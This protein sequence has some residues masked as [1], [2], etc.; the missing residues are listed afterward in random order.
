M[1]QH[2]G[3]RAEERSP[4][5]APKLALFGCFYKLGTKPGEAR[6]LAPKGRFFEKVGLWRSGGG[7]SHVRVGWLCP[8]GCL[9][10]IYCLCCGDKMVI[11]L[12]T[13]ALHCTCRKVVSTSSGHLVLTWL[14]GHLVFFCPGLKSLYCL[15]SF[16]KRA[17]RAQR[18]G[19][20][21]LRH[22]GWVSMK[23]QKFA[24]HPPVK[25]PILFLITLVIRKF[26]VIVLA[27]IIECLPQ[28]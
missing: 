6:V 20:F 23:S 7:I 25:C 24:T 17:A 9:A 15:R 11:L 5:L 21:F 13:A 27:N 3:G 14:P 22:L 26:I 10:A 19:Q 2:K 8:V 12:I 4:E 28:C 1:S 18:R 16:A